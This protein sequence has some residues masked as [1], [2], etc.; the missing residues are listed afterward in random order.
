MGVVGYGQ[1]S[2]W[3]IMGF[4][5]FE[6]VNSHTIYDVE[7]IWNVSRHRIHITRTLEQ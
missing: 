6:T 2:C 7:T 1:G 3:K 4:P 5:K